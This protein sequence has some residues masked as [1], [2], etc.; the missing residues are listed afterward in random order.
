MCG[1]RH[2]KSRS[3][4]TP[5]TKPRARFTVNELAVDA[6]AIKAAHGHP[7]F[8]VTGTEVDILLS[9]I[10]RLRKIEAAAKVQHEA[11]GAYPGLVE[12]LS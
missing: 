8:P 3:S 5:L 7:D 4:P 6:I 12:A 2:V 11:Y 9:E 1:V 10:D